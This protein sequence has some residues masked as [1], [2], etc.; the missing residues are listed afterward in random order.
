MLFRSRR[1]RLNSLRNHLTHLFVASFRLLC[2][3]ERLRVYVY[4]RDGI[5]VQPW[6]RSIGAHVRGSIVRGYS[7]FPL[8]LTHGPFGQEARSSG[9]VSQRR[10]AGTRLQGPASGRW[11]CNTTYHSPVLGASF[12]LLAVAT[13]YHSTE[14]LA[15]KG[16]V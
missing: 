6:M 5:L 11:C 2:V 4:V 1:Y 15:R 13:P 9:T 12:R 7:G 8:V 3:C 10:V 14:P 16:R